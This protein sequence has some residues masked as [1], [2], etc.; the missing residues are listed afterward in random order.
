MTNKQQTEIRKIVKDNIT[1]VL[2]DYLTK[3]LVTRIRNE[4]LAG[5]EWDLGHMDEE[6]TP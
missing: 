4:I 1:E 2:S 3:D 5:V 6:E